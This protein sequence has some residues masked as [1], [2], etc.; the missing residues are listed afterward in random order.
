M[1]RKI[2]LVMMIVTCFTISLAA[3]L[4][5]K[6]GVIPGLSAPVDALKTAAIEKEL[7]SRTIT[8]TIYDAKGEA[9]AYS[10]SIDG[11]RQYADS[12]IYSSLLSY[13]SGGLEYWY[14]DELYS[15]GEKEYEDDKG[16]LYYKGSDMW[17]TI[18][19][20]LQEKAFELIKDEEDASIVILDK[21]GAVKVM[22][23]SNTFNIN[24]IEMNYEEIVDREGTLLNPAKDYIY[25]PGSC[26][27]PIIGTTLID[28]GEEDY[29]VNDRGGI[30][31]ESGETINN[32]GSVAHGSIQVDQAMKVSSNVFFISAAEELG[33]NKIMGKYQEFKIGESFD[34][35]FG[36]VSS[37]MNSLEDEYDLAMA[38]IGQNAGISTVQLAMIMNGV[39]TGEMLKPYIVKK[40]IKD[41]KV[42]SIG[43]KMVLSKTSFKDESISKMNDILNSTAV[44]Y[45]LTEDVCGVK[46]LAKTGTAEVETDDGTQNVATLLVAVPADNPKYF[47]AIQSRH[48]DKWG[49][50]FVGVAHE[51]IKLL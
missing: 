34:T 38:A 37:T 9:L 33:A 25:P 24:D 30:T 43:N 18:D 28:D 26:L 48:T 41:D 3:T 44:S 17:L 21:N 12:Y 49:K 32:A 2:K 47:M 50:S 51:L 6:A 4:V 27:K 31:I 5:V 40:M 7:N 39:T 19:N 36:N 1:E 8:G 16:E 22:T 13:H 20:S 10:S 46:V 11:N 23:S 15:H 42:V 14:N 35:D 45:G 29:I